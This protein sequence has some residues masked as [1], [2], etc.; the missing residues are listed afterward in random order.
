MAASTLSSTILWGDSRSEQVSSML[1]RESWLGDVIGLDIVSSILFHEEA[2][3]NRSLWIIRFWPSA[4]YNLACDQKSGIA[5]MHRGTEMCP[6][7]VP[8]HW[9]L[10]A[11]ENCAT[12]KGATPFS[13]AAL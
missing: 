4:C 2:F 5:Q 8:V 7:A 1:G 9:F 11:T 6:R 10:V 12:R 13:A 3:V